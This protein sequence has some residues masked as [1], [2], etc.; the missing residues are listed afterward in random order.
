MNNRTMIVG[1]LL[2]AATGAWAQPRAVVDKETVTL[3]DILWKKPA[4]VRY[5]LTNKGNKPLLITEVEPSC[6]CMNADWSRKAIAPHASAELSVSYDA[7]LLGHFQ[8][9]VLVYTNASEEPLVLSLSGVVRS[10]I[11]DYAE[12]YPVQMGTWHLDRNHIEFPDAEKGSTP[13]VELQLVNGSDKP[14]EPVLMH[15]PHYIEAKAVPEVVM[16]GRAGKVELTLHPDRLPSLGLVHTSVYLSRHA[17]DQVGEENEIRVMGVALP[18]FSQLT[19]QQLALAPK[20]ELS[21]DH[22][23]IVMKGKKK[24]AQTLVI[25][26]RG[27]S[28][29]TFSEVQVTAP[30]I[31]VSIPRRS[32]LPGQSAKVKITALAQYLKKYN[33][34]PRV[35]M[36]TNDPHRPKVEIK[37]NIK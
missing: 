12:S 10:E 14:A 32:L 18:D 19:P 21:A 5:K 35:W 27:R 28:E 15:L 30:S 11:T 36:I 25:T 33:T 1:L 3:G 6:G 4:T 34:T 9:E 20:T 24:V 26:N 22:L 8:K 23:E 16:P 37:V 29:L 13:K 31:N 17:G 7:Q 2:A